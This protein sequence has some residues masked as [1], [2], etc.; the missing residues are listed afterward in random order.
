MENFASAIRFYLEL[1]GMEEE[2]LAKHDFS[3]EEIAE[4]FA[5]LRALYGIED[6]LSV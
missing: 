5:D 4:G 6:V 2:E 3:R 1:Y